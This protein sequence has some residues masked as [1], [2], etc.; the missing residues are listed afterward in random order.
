MSLALTPDQLRYSFDCSTIQC[1]T[2]ADLVAPTTIIGQPR[3][4]KAIEFG[5]NMKSPGYNIYVLGEHGTGRTTAIQRFV[6]DR[7]ITEDVPDD[8]IYVFNFRTHHQPLAIKLPTGV[9]YRLRDAMAQLVEVMRSEIPN[10][11][12]TDTFRIEAQQVQREFETKQN[13]RLNEMRNKALSLGALVGNTPEGMRIVPAKDGQPLSQEEIAARTPEEIEAWQEV[14]YDIQLELQDMGHD[15]RQMELE[16][17][18]VMEDI[19]KRIT[20]GVVEEIM[21]S[22][23]Q[24]FVDHDVLQKYFDEVQAD[25]IDNVNFFQQAAAE[26]ESGPGENWFRR[27]QINVIVDNHLTKGAPVIVEY[28]PS[29]PRLLGRVEHEPAF[30]G[31]VITD[32]TLVRGGALHQAN[33]GYLVLRAQDLFAEPGAWDALKRA[34]IGQVVRPDD[35]AIRGGTAGSSLDPQPLPLNLKVILVGPARLYYYLYAAD[36][37]FSTVFKVMADFDALVDRTDENEN[38]YAR[39]IAAFCHEEGLHHLTP[40]AVGRVIEYGARLAGTQNKLSGRFG[41][42]ADLVREADYCAREA[43]R[44]V[45]DLDDVVDAIDNRIYL[46]NRIETRLLEHLLDG[47]RLV[48]TDGEVVGQ[49]NALT[50]SQIG[51]HAFGQPSRLTVRAYVGK[52]GVVQ[53]DREVEL[54]GP[55]HN[56]GLMTLIGYLGGTYATD[57][58]LSLSAQITFEQNYGG[59]DGDSAS[60]TELY[61]LL[62]TLADTPIKQS[63]AVTGSVNQNGEVQPIGGVTEKIEGWFAVCNSRGLTGD[64]GVLIPQSN[65]SDLMLRDEVVEAVAA[66]KFNI[67]AVESIDQGI[68]ILTGRPASEIHTKVKKRLNELAQAMLQYE[69]GHS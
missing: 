51:D 60:S 47:K 9:G 38:A 3:G 31:G 67:Y 10:A 5:I 23:R 30:G 18:K 37:D 58:P 7:A 69:H 28:D 26:E 55:L 46:Q 6:E 50:V 36:G 43:K 48:A 4:V 41:L 53:I 57:Q 22:I 59:I 24:T 29:V 8:W 16:A 44:E 34:L 13:A 54:A 39:F 32:F 35:P 42:I 45:V 19:V 11:F 68:E 17:Q 20:T 2:T 63:L 33:G 1:T 52:T 27:Y 14:V 12:D 65:V 64:Q 40:E 66:G 61:G 25:V 15:I 21:S 56:K 62:S 49:I